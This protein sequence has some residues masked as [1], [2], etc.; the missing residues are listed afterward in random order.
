MKEHSLFL[1]AGFTPKNTKL[2][3]QANDYKIKFE[4]HSFKET[5]KHIYI[6]RR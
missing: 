6:K 3:K 4:K 2:S 1:E 5:Q